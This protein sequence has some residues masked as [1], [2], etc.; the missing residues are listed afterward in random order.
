MRVVMVS[1]ARR[2]D[3][4]VRDHHI[5]R[6]SYRGAPDLIL[7]PHELMAEGLHVADDPKRLTYDEQQRLHF[8]GSP[9][10]CVC[11]MVAAD[12]DQPVFD[13]IT[14]VPEYQ[15]AMEEEAKA[16]P[17]PVPVPPAPTKPVAKTAKKKR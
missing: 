6:D 5:W 9:V 1:N 14:G 16:E 4:L 2:Y 3:D 13:C 7:V 11:Q 10:M 8:A 15:A 12:P 17:V